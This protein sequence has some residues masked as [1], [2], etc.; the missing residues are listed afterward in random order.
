MISQPSLF[1]WNG[2]QTK[3]LVERFQKYYPLRHVMPCSSG[4]AAIHIAVLAAGIAPG[5]EVIVPPVTDLGTV[6][7]VL[8]QQAVPVFADIEPH[9]YTLSA[10]DVRKKITRRT[11]AIIAVHLMGNPCDIKALKQV[12]D[13]HGLLLIE[14]CAQ[15]WGAM[16]GDQPVGTIGDLACYSLNDFKHIGCG[17]GG[18]VATND[19]RFGALLQR[20]G[21]KDYDRVQE[22]R[23]SETLAPN[24]RITEP[25]AAVAAVQMTR[26]WEITGQ[27]G[28]RGRRLTDLLR[29]VAGVQ[30]PEAEP[31][32]RWSCWHYILRLVPAVLRCR[33]KQFTDALSAEGVA[34]E[35]GYMP[36]PLYRYPL[37]QNHAFFAGGWPIRQSGVTKMDYRKVGCPEAEAFLKT[38]VKVRLNEAMDDAWIDAMAAA[39]AKV[40]RWHVKAGVERTR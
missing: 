9:R 35:A 29:G 23:L 20:R 1:Y 37:F 40:A 30:P 5:D 25:Q 39:I 27:R 36:A 21:D 2:P 19:A 13:E 22:S 10:A 32:D 6:I 7:G 11:K 4:T 12:A 18:L 16:S 3:L 26:M 8:Y 38:C 17:D 14:D 34:C 28:E 31:H 24:Y 15:A 33:P